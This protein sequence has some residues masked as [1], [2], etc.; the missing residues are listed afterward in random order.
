VAEIWLAP[1]KKKGS[2]ALGYNPVSF[3]SV[4]HFVLRVRLP[5]RSPKPSRNLAPP[6]VG[7]KIARM[8]VLELP[9]LGDFIRDCED[10]L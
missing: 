3:S 5:V 4:L 2:L 6:G 10:L 1:P 7:V 9:M 8:R